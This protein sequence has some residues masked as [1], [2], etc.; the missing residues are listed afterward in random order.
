[1]ASSSL[2]MRIMCCSVSP[3]R[4]P[5]TGSIF[6]RVSLP[7]SVFARSIS[8]T[9][10]AVQSMSPTLS[11]RRQS[12]RIPASA[13]PSSSTRASPTTTT[14]ALSRVAGDASN[15][16]LTSGPMPVVS[17]SINPTTGR[18]SGRGSAL[19]SCFMATPIEFLLSVRLAAGVLDH[20]R[21]LGQLGAQEG[22][23]LFRTARR[24]LQPLQGQLFAYGGLVQRRDHRSVELVHD[25]PGQPGRADQTVPVRRL[26]GPDARGLGDGGHIRQESG[27]AARRHRERADFSGLDLRDRSGG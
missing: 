4:R 26:V 14:R 22:G 2:P 16:T 11:T 5:D 10:G 1:M 15:L 23:K 18:N 25:G 8:G 27:A 24:R 19:L 7:G 6:P 21:P 17:P 9:P 12:R 20:F 3:A 13:M